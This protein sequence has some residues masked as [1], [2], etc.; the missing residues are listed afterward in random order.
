M[1]GIVSSIGLKGIEGYRVEVEVQLLPG[2]EGVNIV[3][4]R[5]LRLKSQ[6][7]V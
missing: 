6:K 2:V 3:G 4:F 7:I 5:M 1:A